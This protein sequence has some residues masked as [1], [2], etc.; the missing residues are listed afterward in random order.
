MAGLFDAPPLGKWEIHGPDA[1]EFLDRFYLND[2]T[3]LKPMR[4]R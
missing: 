2:L 3:T 1:V 4:A